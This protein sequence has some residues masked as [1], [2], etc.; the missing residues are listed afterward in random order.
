MAMR[1]ALMPLWLT[2]ATTA[3]EYGFDLRAW[4]TTVDAR[5]EACVAVCV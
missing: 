4:W 2:V 3:L 5:D 1:A